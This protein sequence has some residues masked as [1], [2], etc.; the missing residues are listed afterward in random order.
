MSQTIEEIAKDIV[1]AWIS[2]GKAPIGAETGQLEGQRLGDIYDD[3]EKWRS[4][5][6]YLAQRLAATESA[7]QADRDRLPATQDVTQQR[8]P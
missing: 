5:A 2:T 8:S 3:R 6:D 1:V 4:V 7:R